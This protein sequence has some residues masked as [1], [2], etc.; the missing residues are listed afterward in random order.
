M[1]VR[2]LKIYQK[3]P[4][5]SQ[6]MKNVTDRGGMNDFQWCYINRENQVK[7][8]PVYPEWPLDREIDSK[9]NRCPCKRRWPVLADTLL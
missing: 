1:V 6:L 3:D 9:R 5:Q 7:M 2:A 8:Y 4:A